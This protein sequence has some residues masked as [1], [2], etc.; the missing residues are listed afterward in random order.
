MNQPSWIKD[1]KKGKVI[2]DQITVTGRAKSIPPDSLPMGM[3]SQNGGEGPPPPPQRQNTQLPMGVSPQGSR[4]TGT[5]VDGSLQPQKMAGQAHEGEGILSA[6]AMQ[7]FTPQEFESFSRALEGGVIDKNLFLQS[8]GEPAVKEYAS[9]GIVGEEPFKP[10]ADLPT[11]GII[12]AANTQATPQ[13]APAETGIKP[14]STAEPSTASTATKTTLPTSTLSGVATSRIPG[15]NANDST[16]VMSNARNRASGKA[17]EPMD[18]QATEMLA[19]AGRNMQSTA[20]N[21]VQRAGLNGQGAANEVVRNVD[22]SLMSNLTN[23]LLNR[24]IKKD[25]MMTGGAKDLITIGN[26]INANKASATDTTS[27]ISQIISSGAGKAAVIGDMQLRSDIANTLGVPLNDAAVDTELNM[28]YDANVA[29]NNKQF[30]STANDLMKG[31]VDDGATIDQVLADD[32]IRRNTALNM[33]LD[34]DDLNN[35]TAIDGKINTWFKDLSTNE[36]DKTVNDYIDSGLLDEDFTK[37]DGWREDLTN[38]IQDMMNNSDWD[39]E[40]NAP[41]EG[42]GMPWDNPNTY[43]K[44]ND[45]NGN[46]IGTENYTVDG[47]ITIEGN[48]TKFINKAGGAVTNTE[49][50]AVWNTLNSSDRTKY[51]KSGEMDVEQF[52]KDNFRVTTGPDG[53]QLPVT[54]K[55]DYFDMISDPEYSGKINTF[56]EMWNDTSMETN[57]NEETGTGETASITQYTYYDES[58]NPQVTEKIN[59][60]GFIYQQLSDKFLGNGELLDESKGQFS[61]YWNNGKGWIVNKDGVITNLDSQGVN[62]EAITTAQKALEPLLAATRSGKA[63][64]QT[65]LR[66]GDTATA[67]PTS[68]V[69]T[70]DVTNTLLESDAKAIVA[71]WDTLDPSIKATGDFILETKPTNYHY[72]AGLS[73]EYHLTSDMRDWIDDNI[74]RLYL[75]KTDG[76]IYQVAG[77]NLKASR[78]SV[79]SVKL[80]D[81]VTAQEVEFANY[82]VGKNQKSIPFS[83]EKYQ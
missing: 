2:P 47:E 81:A 13:S 24:Q 54:T 1:M 11:G 34:P 23:D 51:F 37:V 40:T 16:T 6:N 82:N 76:R 69:K 58:G 3:F 71:A 9:G 77:A 59:G 61:Q 33:G 43:F 67:T 52:L 63:G 57:D 70:I 80:I 15:L 74:G 12:G 8:I 20:A 55:D 65:T 32:R 78:G 83:G 39:Y 7:N 36:V 79:G 62:T 19:K 45:W 10:I 30:G 64:T 21:T 22:Q 42:S 73:S 28:L 48:G 72:D 26:A 29:T 18:V 31:M 53:K 5:G 56:L 35:K 44:Y 27:R 41:K 68:G 25:E 46:E 14:I 50:T 60:L 38:T 49:A 4:L 75:S 66:N 17:F